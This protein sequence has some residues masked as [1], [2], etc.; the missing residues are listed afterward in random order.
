M[1]EQ[2]KRQLISLVILGVCVSFSAGSYAFINFI[3]STR[4]GHLHLYMDWELKIPMIEWM[5]L[6]Y[7]SA[8]AAPFFSYW[9]LD[10]REI[11]AMAKAFIFATIFSSVVFL[12]IPTTL[13][14]PR[15][16]ELLGTFKDLYL[17]LWQADH[18]YNLVPSMHVVIAFLLLR[19]LLDK[20][21]PKWSK[22]LV[23]TFIVGISASIIFVYQHHLIDLVSGLGLAYFCYKSIYLRALAKE[24]K[25]AVVIPLEQKDDRDKDIAA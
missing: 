22:A 25:T 5:I 7:Y 4:S 9:L 18:P 3:N 11:K 16:P 6:F 14:Y 8:Y 15:D 13:G 17:L 20:N 2:K 19:P 24:K 1:S 21:I 23:A 12:A 10:F